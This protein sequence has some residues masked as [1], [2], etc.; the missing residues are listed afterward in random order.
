MAMG[1][2]AYQTVFLLVLLIEVGAT[3]T[4]M[5]PND[6]THASCAAAKSDALLQQGKN[7]VHLHTD[8]DESS[9]LKCHVMYLMADNNLD[10]ALSKDLEE[11]ISN[12]AAVS[13]PLYYPL[14][15]ID[16]FSKSNPKAIDG[17]VGK[18][19]GEAE[20]HSGVRY[21]DKDFAT[22]KLKVKRE[23][24][25]KHSD[26]PRTLKKF[27]KWAFKRCRKQAKSSQ[28]NPAVLVTFGSH[29]YGWK[30]FGGDEAE[31]LLQDV[32]QAEMN[33]SSR[34][35]KNNDIRKAIEQSMAAVNPPF[36]KLD[37]LGFDACS[38]SSYSAMYAFEGLSTWYMASQGTE[39]GHGW[40]YA[41][42]NPSLSVKEMAEAMIDGFAKGLHGQTS[43]QKPKTLALI[44]SDDF[45][46]F[47]TAMD[48]LA[49][50]MR[51]AA[52]N[53]K[54]NL[55]NSV[56]FQFAILGRSGY[57]RLSTEPGQCVLHIVMR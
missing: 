31:S 34:G 28:S 5:G 12:T 37:L 54:W 16:R 20:Y 38:M 51:Y 29:G 52:V 4:C 11:V 30:G 25:E 13:N 45:S 40:D 6:D 57:R 17:L 19:G 43:H 22:N 10:A 55:L 14:V 48:T 3:A 27:L 42:L 44:N 23:M 39:P 46:T 50:K 36:T 24:R 56:S 9:S 49:D 1:T 32:S 8:A 26:D 53:R 47:K 2:G 15:F 35:I 21:I 33:S 7:H 18:S 41:S